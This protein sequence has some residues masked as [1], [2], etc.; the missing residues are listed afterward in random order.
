MELFILIL[1]VLVPVYIINGVMCM[2][3][4]KSDR[5]Y[6][7]SLR[8]IEMECEKKAK[9]LQIE[10][11]EQQR[12]LDIEMDAAKQLAAR[13]AAEPIIFNLTITEKDANGVEIGDPKPLSL[14]LT[15]DEETATRLVNILRG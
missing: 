14:K 13:R 3:N 15:L 5:R 11:E 8:Q 7:E 9:K 6:E 4:K 2:W 10:R 12:Q 1:A